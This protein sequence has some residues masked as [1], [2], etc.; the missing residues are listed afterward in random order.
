MVYPESADARS[1]LFHDHG[2]HTLILRS[3]SQCPG[4]S[5]RGLCQALELLL[6]TRNGQQDLNEACGQGFQKRK[7]PWSEGDWRAELAE[8]SVPRV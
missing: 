2:L 7:R 1:S 8:V 3:W 6:E 5:V 4:F